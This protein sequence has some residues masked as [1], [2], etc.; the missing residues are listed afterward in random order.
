MAYCSG[1]DNKSDETNTPNYN[2]NG[3]NGVDNIKTRLNKST[4]RFIQN[5]NMEKNK[6]IETM[7]LMH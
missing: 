5:R 6:L 4:D 7:F 3:I 1:D 2:N